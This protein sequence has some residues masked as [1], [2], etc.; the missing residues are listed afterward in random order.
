MLGNIA[1][2]THTQTH[3]AIIFIHKE[4]FTLKI[5]MYGKNYY[6]AGSKKL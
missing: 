2:Y 6:V 5:T 4:N 3:R 1:T